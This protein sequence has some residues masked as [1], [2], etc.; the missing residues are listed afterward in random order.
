MNSEVKEIYGTI[1]VNFLN[2]W[3]S[4]FP[5]LLLHCYMKVVSSNL[6]LEPS[7]ESYFS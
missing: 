3:T 4:K 5:K 2:Y 7:F 6:H 1:P